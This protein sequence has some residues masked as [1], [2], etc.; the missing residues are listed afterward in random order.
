M[1]ISRKYTISGL[2][3][4]YLE[5]L[6]VINPK[7]TVKSLSTLVTDSFVLFRWMGE[8][9][10]WNRINRIIEDEDE[11]EVIRDELEKTYLC[12]RKKPKADS[13]SYARNIMCLVQFLKI[14]DAIDNARV[15]KPRVIVID[16]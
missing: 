4:A 2:K 1:N 13:K 11:I 7:S 14:V 15:K 16:E 5:Y 9:D 10:A 8:E 12:K 6:Q 3:K